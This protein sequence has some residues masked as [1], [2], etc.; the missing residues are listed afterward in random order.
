MKQHK[1]ILLAILLGMVVLAGSIG[2]IVLASD[3]G[4]EDS[5]LPESVSFID[6]VLSIYYEKTGIAIDKEALQEA[7]TQASEE[8]RAEHPCIRLNGRLFDDKAL[9]Q[10][11][12]DEIDAWMEARPEFPIDEFKAWLE[13]RPER[14]TDEFK[15]WLEARPEFPNDEFKAWM[16][17]RPE[18]VLFDFGIRSKFGP[19]LFG[20]LDKSG[21][22]SHMFGFF[23][24]DENN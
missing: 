22:R 24:P 8:M 12:Q 6:R 20:H 5:T 14:S 15:A 7:L 2:G 17:A 11:Q 16:E 4:E 1:K 10:E 13:S 23:R 3:E 18:D 19:G 9:T 21:G